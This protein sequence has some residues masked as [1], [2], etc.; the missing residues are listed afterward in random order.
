[1][2]EITFTTDVEGSD[3]SIWEH[4]LQYPPETASYEREVFSSDFTVK[5]AVTIEM[6][7][8]GLKSISVYPYGV[9]GGFTLT[10]YDKD[11]NELS[12]TDYLIDS[13][14]LEKDG[15]V[16]N[17]EGLDDRDLDDSIAPQDIEINYKDKTIIV[18]F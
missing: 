7:D 2:N 4:E 6:R 14:I 16:L 11:G 12:E 18:V 3:V 10:S 8:W 13:D 15:W 5:W 9:K 1:M 17:S